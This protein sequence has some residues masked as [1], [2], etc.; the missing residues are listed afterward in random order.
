[1][2]AGVQLEDQPFGGLGLGVV[3]AGVGDGR[4]AG[5]RGHGGRADHADEPTAIQR[6]IGAV[7]AARFVRLVHGT[8]S[9]LWC[10]RSGNPS[11]PDGIEPN[12]AVVGFFSLDASW[13]S[14]IHSSREKAP[15]MRISFVALTPARGSLNTTRL[16]P[17]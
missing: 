13:P 1:V 12:R 15:L 2:E 11:C 4:H 9:W 16:D 3:T 17:F 6:R 14:A 8:P 10:V 5:R 7:L